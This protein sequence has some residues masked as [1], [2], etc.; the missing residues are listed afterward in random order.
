MALSRLWADGTS[1]GRSQGGGQR[2]GGG[3]VQQSAGHDPGEHVRYLTGRS[4]DF[5]FTA[6]PSIARTPYQK[7][8]RKLRRQALKSRRY[9]NEVHRLG[10]A[11]QVVISG[12][13]RGIRWTRLIER[14]DTAVKSMKT[15]VIGA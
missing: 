15:L 3:M 6:M 5:Q 12:S 1:L 11:P 8:Q 2:P 10:G 4:T 7:Q 13:S 14:V 9:L